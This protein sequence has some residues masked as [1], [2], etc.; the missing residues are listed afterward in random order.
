MIYGMFITYNVGAFNFFIM[1][2]KDKQTL[3]CNIFESESIDDEFVWESMLSQ[4]PEVEYVIVDGVW[5]DAGE[6][7]IKEACM[8][9]FRGIENGD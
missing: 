7:T 8:A 4:Y 2:K 9:V 6:L 3:C 1:E 5:E